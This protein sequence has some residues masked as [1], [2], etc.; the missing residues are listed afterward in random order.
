MITL[1]YVIIGV[2][3][4]LLLIDM[5]DDDDPPSG[6]LVPIKIPVQPTDRR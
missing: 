4:I 5:M 6:T 2:G 1:A 3:L